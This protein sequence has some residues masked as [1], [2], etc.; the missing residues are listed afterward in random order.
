MLGNIQFTEEEKYDVN[1]LLDSICTKLEGIIN[2]KNIIYNDIL[3]NNQ[4]LLSVM[5]NPEFVAVEI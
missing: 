1:N 5:H 4:N 2:D 3:K